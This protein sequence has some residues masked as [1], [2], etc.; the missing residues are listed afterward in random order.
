MKQFLS[1]WLYVWELP[2]N[3]LALILFR[4]FGI[5][6]QD[7]VITLNGYKR[8]EFLWKLKTAV[9]LGRYVLIGQ[10]LRDTRQDIRYH[11]L[12]HCVQ[13]IHWGWLYLVVIGIPS[14]WVNLTTR[15][16]RRMYNSK[17][18]RWFADIFVS[19]NEGVYEW[20]YS[21]YPEKQANNAVFGK[22]QW[23]YDTKTNRLLY[24]GIK[25]KVVFE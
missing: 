15:I 22:D 2:Q 11:E 19:K 4:I 6:G 7:R 14:M 1:F 24:V 21:R 9:S 13:S 5:K 17:P 8:I 25:A 12:G 10:I 18:F 23:K 16:I 20:A 3:V